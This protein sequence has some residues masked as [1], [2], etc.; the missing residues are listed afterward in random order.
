MSE[1]FSLKLGNAH[2]SRL[3]SRNGAPSFI[4]GP[5]GSAL[6]R[7]STDCK[8]LK[9]KATVLVGRQCAFVKN[10]FKTVLHNQHFNTLRLFN[11]EVCHD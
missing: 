7:I 4:C 1:L 8:N 6:S 9:L 3:I 5:V 2:A 10:D 11:K